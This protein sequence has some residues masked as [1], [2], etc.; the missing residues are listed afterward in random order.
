MGGGWLADSVFQL[1]SSVDV[2]TDCDKHKSLSVENSKNKMRAITV[3][4]ERYRVVKD[5]ESP[6]PNSIVFQ[7]G[8]RVKV[9]KEF[10][11]DPDWQNWIWCEG[12]NG[13]KAWV[14]EDYLNSDGRNGMF[15]REYNAMELSVQVG[16]TL[17]V[18]EIVN[19]FGMSEKPDGSRGWVPMRNMEIEKK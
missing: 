11:E 10:K 2:H 15:N 14:P 5:Y 6:Y 7:K 16:E 3:T 1:F 8:E 4:S 13:K 9:C 18:C 17:T 12:K 19:G